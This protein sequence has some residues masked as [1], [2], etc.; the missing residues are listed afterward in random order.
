[1][2]VLSQTPPCAGNAERIARN[3]R[4]QTSAQNARLVSGN[5]AHSMYGIP[6]PTGFF[7]WPVSEMQTESWTKIMDTFL[8]WAFKIKPRWLNA[9]LSLETSCYTR[10]SR[11]VQMYVEILS[12]ESDLA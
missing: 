6:P 11:W 4:L 3:A 12:L 2:A 10:C 1:M 7:F 9:E 8:H 5:S